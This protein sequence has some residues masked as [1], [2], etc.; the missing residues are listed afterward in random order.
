M[1]DRLES[2][3]AEIPVNSPEKFRLSI[4]TLTI[5]A[6]TSWDDAQA[7]HVINEVHDAVEKGVVAIQHRLHEI[8]PELKITLDE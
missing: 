4:Y 7:E 3:S 8:N 5:N 1:S 6:P 2:F